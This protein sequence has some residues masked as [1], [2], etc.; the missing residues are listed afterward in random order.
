[1]NC[2]TVEA[3]IRP[4]LRTQYSKLKSSNLRIL[5]FSNFQILNPQLPLNSKLGTFLLI[6]GVE[7]FRFLF[8]KFLSSDYFLVEKLFEFPKSIHF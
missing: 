7:Y 2:V 3:L 5:K 8:F 1:M 4:K 6:F